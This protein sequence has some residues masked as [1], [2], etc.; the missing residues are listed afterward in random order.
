MSTSQAKRSSNP[1]QLSTG[2]I[3]GIAVSI[4]LI[5]IIPPLLIACGF[6]IRRPKW[7]TNTATTRLRT[8]QS[9]TATGGSL[10]SQPRKAELEVGG[11]KIRLERLHD[12]AK[13]EPEGSQL[14]KAKQ[15]AS[16]IKSAKLLG[17]QP[18]RAELEDGEYTRRLERLHDGAK[19][20]LEGV[21][22]QKAWW[23]VSSTR[24]ARSQPRPVPAELGTEPVTPGPYE[25]PAG[26]S[27][28]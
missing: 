28:P 23:R 6:R 8:N 10:G 18:W 26:N 21:R 13:Q 2:A 20:E 11:Y 12:R 22:P 5:V 17:S 7:R 27:V 19:P 25:L 14:Q 24:P 1:I 16:S 9:K 4:A 15:N 3:A